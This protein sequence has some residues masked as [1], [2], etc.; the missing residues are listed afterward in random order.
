[1]FA[2]LNTL[3]S[4]FNVFG[5]VQRRFVHY[6]TMCVHL[7]VVSPWLPW[8]W[9]CCSQ[10]FC[11]TGKMAMTLVQ[12]K[13]A[14]ALS[15]SLSCFCSLS[16]SI[17]LSLVLSFFLSLSLFLSL[18]I[19]LSLPIYLSLSSIF[20]SLYISLYHFLS[21]SISIST[22][23][24]N[25]LSLYIYTYICLSLYTL[26][27]QKKYY[28][29]HLNLSVITMIWTCNYN[30]ST[31][32]VSILSNVIAMASIVKYLRMTDLESTNQNCNFNCRIKTPSKL[33]LHKLM[34]G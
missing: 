33:I 13:L 29:Q 31:Q 24:S 32:F 20:P 17:S 22:Y 34:L 8:F 27:Q 7:F 6:T 5:P 15:L 11:E 25:A 28:S 21:I 23:L 19:Y 30:C 10:N 2:H 4:W 14:R 3:L 9:R 26:K 18:S 1:M 16:L 12:A